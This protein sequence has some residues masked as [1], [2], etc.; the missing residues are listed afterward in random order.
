MLSEFQKLTR[1]E[2]LAPLPHHEVFIEVTDVSTVRSVTR[3]LDKYLSAADSRVGVAHPVHFNFDQG[4]AVASASA[5]RLVPR[6]WLAVDGAAHGRRGGHVPVGTVGSRRR[7]LR[8]R[9]RPLAAVARG[10]HGILRVGIRRRMLLVFVHA[11]HIEHPAVAER[12]HLA[13]VGAAAAATTRRW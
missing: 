8:G 10:R 12:P 9:V 11:A 13:T 5:Q 1:E 4:T 3:T 6:L 2:I 7:C